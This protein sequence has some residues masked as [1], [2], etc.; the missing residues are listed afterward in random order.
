MGYLRICAAARLYLS[1]SQSSS[2]HRFQRPRQVWYLVV[3]VDIP[4]YTAD[5]EDREPPFNGVAFGVLRGGAWGSTI[6]LTN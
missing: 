3:V 2:Y 1:H 5:S 6:L 4:E